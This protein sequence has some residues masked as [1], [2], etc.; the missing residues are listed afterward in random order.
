MVDLVITEKEIV[1][2]DNAFDDVQTVIKPF[3]RKALSSGT[4]EASRESIV[5]QNLVCD[6]VSVFQ[7]VFGEDYEIL[8]QTAVF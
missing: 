5:G 6:V 2:Y 8:A 7:Q 3:P 1:H 4:N